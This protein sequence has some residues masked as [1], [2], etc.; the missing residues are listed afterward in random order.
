MPTNRRTISR[1]RRPTFGPEVL[2][3]FAELNAVPMRD[4]KDE[5]KA[6]DRELAEMLSIG[7]EWLFSI[8]SVTDGR[9][10]RTSGMTTPAYADHLRVRA[11]REQLLA[12]LA[13]VPPE[14]PRMSAPANLG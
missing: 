5:F 2:A 10:L 9:P 1:P 6:R 3:L 13:E 11:V 12:A 8:A 4:R 14:G 7:D